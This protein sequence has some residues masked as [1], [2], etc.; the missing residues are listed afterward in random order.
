[1]NDSKIAVIG[2]KDTI[3]I[4]RSLGMDLFFTDTADPKALIKDLVEKQ[5]PIILVTEREAILAGDILDNLADRPYPI[6]VPIPDGIAGY[7]LGAGK[8]AD[9]VKKATGE[10]FNNEQ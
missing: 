9:S 2:K 4:F 8:I 3:L 10:Q 5:Y 7:G 1:M 6:V